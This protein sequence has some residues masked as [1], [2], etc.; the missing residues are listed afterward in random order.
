MLAIAGG[1]ALA[2][3]VAYAQPAPAAAGGPYDW[4]GVYVGA[5]GGWN[6]QDNRVRSTTTVNQLSGVNA[7]AGTVTVP[8]T[9]FASG[10]AGRQTDGFMGGGQLGVN[11]QTGGLLLG[12]EADF[13]GLSGG[14]RGQTSYYTLPATG[15]TTGST[16]AVRHDI[17]PQWVATLRGRVGFAMDRTLIYGTGGAA[18]ADLRNRASYTYTPTVTSGVTTANPGTTYGPYSNSGSRSGTRTGWTAGAGVEFL[19]APNVTLGAEYRHTEIGTGTGFMGS[20]GANGVSERGSSTFR[21]DAVL[22]RVNF[23]FSNWHGW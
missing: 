4:S 2:G 18:W 6:W 19:M 3:S 1:A 21:D 14:R 15:L 5:N 7:G 9:T 10:R 11:A 16:V 23:K 17:S 22:G 8:S 12:V 20:T 13:D